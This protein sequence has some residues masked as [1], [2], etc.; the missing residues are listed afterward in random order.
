[1]LE[2]LLQVGL[3]AEHLFRY[4]HSEFSGGQRRRI[5][6]PGFG[7]IKPEFLILD[8]P[9]SALDVSVQADVLNLLP[10]IAA[11]LG[12]TYFFI[13][14]DLGVITSIANDVARQSRGKLVESGPVGDIFER[15]TN[16]YSRMLLDAMPDPD[17]DRSPFRQKVT[18]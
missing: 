12:L 18:A 4:P 3:R 6:V 13:S 1:M 14:H 9:T 10:R 16:E 15:P 2:L 8:E 5:I 7:K 11:E 17:P